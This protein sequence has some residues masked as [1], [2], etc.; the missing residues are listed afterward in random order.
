MSEARHV[1]LIHGNWS[2][3]EQ[4]A[5][6]RTAF[7]ERGFIA[8]APTL[9]HHEL[10]IRE[11]A[12]KIASLRLRDYVDDLLAFV[13]SLETPP[14][15]VGHSMG[16]LIAQLVAAR[17]PH[18]GLV[19]AC[20]APAAGIAGSTPANR[21]MSM[22][23]FLRP[24]AWAKPVPPPT[25]ERF[26][27]WIAN[28]QSEDTAR[29]IFDGLVCD[30]GRAQWEMLLATLKLSKTTL[31]DAAAVDTPVLVLGGEYDLI[32]PERV[33]QQT[34]AQYQHADVVLIPNSDHMVFSGS[35]LPITMRYIDEWLA[36]NQLQP[37]RGTTSP[38]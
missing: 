9:R 30:S 1:V 2:R 20:P 18:I 6:L 27:A 7:D 12:R 35:C 19:A 25:Y 3:G 36:N 38:D 21:R 23:W 24:R 31:V 13:G 22:P 8:H 10:P 15:L 34:A 28:T 33:L 29:E 5:G 14:L 11:G 32:V 17:T 4:L 16:G 37:M 26:R